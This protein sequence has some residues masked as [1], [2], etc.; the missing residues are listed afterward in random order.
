MILP[1]C[2][3]R[4]HIRGC[5]T[6]PPG[7]APLLSTAGTNWVA[8]RTLTRTSVTVIVFAR[9]GEAPRPQSQP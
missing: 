3:T 4:K 8:A 1:G 2:V 7:P 5:R 9:M 6:G